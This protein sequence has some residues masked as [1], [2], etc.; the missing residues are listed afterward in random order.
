MVTGSN[1]FDCV[2]LMMIWPDSLYAL[3]MRFV[4]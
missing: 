1:D 2:L 4:T 3:V